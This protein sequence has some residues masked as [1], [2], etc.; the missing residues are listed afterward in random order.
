MTPTRSTTT[1]NQQLAERLDGVFQQIGALIE[2]SK[3][4]ERGRFVLHE[5]LDK[6]LDA[7]QV[8]A[9]QV[10]GST[11][12]AEIAGQIAAQTRDRVDALD[13]EL[14]PAIAE[15]KQQTKELS[16]D[17]G[18]LKQANIQAGPLLDT[19][20][21]AR[22]LL[23]VL[24]SIAATSGVGIGGVFMFFNTAARDAIRGWLGI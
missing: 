13:R 22:N 4:A 15:L 8:Q 17:V 10:A 9:L 16:D 23:I 11:K 7:V 24:I 2:G 6:L 19:V 12:D 14:K 3:N 21:Q 18:E 20:R 1:T 5:K